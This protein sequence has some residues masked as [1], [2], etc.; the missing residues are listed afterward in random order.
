MKRV[1]ILSLTVLVFLCSCKNKDTNQKPNIIYILAD[2][3]GYAELGCYGQEKI[4]TPNIDKL[5]EKGIRFTQHYAG[6]PV[7]APSRCVLLTGKHPGHAQIRGNDP[8]TERG[9]VWDFE[10]MA[11]DPNLEGQ[12]PLRA[13]TNTIGS[14]LQEVGYKTGIVGKWGLG[15]PLTE[16]IPN[17]QGFDFFY[18]YNCQR[19]AHTFFPVHLWKDTVKVLHIQISQNNNQ[20]IL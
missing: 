12:R 8:W 3:L 7:C 5:A 18:G 20:S 9:P 14:L 15:A 16:G 2:D 17:K 10:A 6:A 19:Q 4:E 13:G 1:F 11:N